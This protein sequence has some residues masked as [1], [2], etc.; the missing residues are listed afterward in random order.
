MILLG[1]H[2]TAKRLDEFVEQAGNHGAVIAATHTFAPGE[3]VSNDS[4]DDVEAVVAAL[5]SAVTMRADIWIP[6]PM[7]DLGREQH[8]RRLD[9]VLER[10]E[11]DL[12]LGPH[13]AACPE[14]G[15]NEVDFALRKEVRA[16]DALDR[17]ALA[18]A[19]IRSLGEEI[20]RYLAG[21][22]SVSDELPVHASLAPWPSA[23]DLTIQHLETLNGPAPTLPASTAP[24]VDRKPFLRAFAA[25]LVHRC[26]LTQGQAAAMI[27]A[28]GHQTARG[29]DFKQVTVSD[30]LRG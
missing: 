17:A 29:L 4:L 24:W 12:L 6:F 23:L 28:T 21:I 10:Y 7:E 30:L 18:A 16:V 27:R 3:A 22:A 1:D 11:L 15:I 20:E 2:E 8:I 26:G 19:G 5:S 14:S 13:L 9:L 25:W